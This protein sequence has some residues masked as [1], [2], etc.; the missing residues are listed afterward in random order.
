MQGVTTYISE[1]GWWSKTQLYGID[2]TGTI[3]A[4]LDGGQ[5]TTVHF[6][7]AGYAQ[8]LIEYKSDTT[9]VTGIWAQLTAD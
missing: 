1:K 7:I 6:P 2:N 9:A 8:V 4:G 5:T 3:V